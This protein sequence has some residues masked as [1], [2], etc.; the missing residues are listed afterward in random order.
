MSANERLDA[1]AERLGIVDRWH[2]LDGTEQRTG[3]ATKR[4][5]I[6]ALGVDPERTSV[7]DLPPAAGEIIVRAGAPAALPA[8]H[9]VRHWALLDEDGGQIAC[10]GQSLPG[11]AAGLYSLTA[12]TGSGDVERL[13]IAAPERPPTVREAGGKARLWGWTTALYGLRSARNMGLGDYEDLAGCSE[14]LAALGGDFVGINPVHVLGYGPSAPVSPY[15][16]SHRAALNPWHLAIDRLPEFEH[17]APAQ[18]WLSENAGELDRVRG[19][20]T[21][22]YASALA[23]LEPAL[24]ALYTCFRQRGERV[25]AFD[26]WRSAEAGDTLRLYALYEALAEVHGADW[27]TWP[28]GLQA[29]DSPETAREAPRLAERVMF[30]LW[31]QWLAD[32]QLADA[33]ARAKGAGMALGLYLDLAVG[34]RPDGAEVW[35]NRDAFARGA[36]LGAP[37]DAFSPGGQNWAL[38]PLS[39]LGL[40]RQRFA[41]F[42]AMLRATMRHAGLVRIDHAFG[43]MRAFWMPQNGVPGSYIRYPFESLLAIVAIEAQRH[44]C[45]VVGEDL[46]VTPDGFRERLAGAGLYGCDLV[47]FERGWDGSFHQ[48]QTYREAAIASFGTH[49]TPTI[50]GWLR[51]R[52]ID[53]RL[54]IGGAGD[55]AELRADRGR[56]REGLEWA[57][58]QT[59]ALAEGEGSDDTVADAVHHA[60][61]EGS[62]TLTAVQLDDAL[63]EIEQANLPGT[64]DEHPNWRRRVAVP[65]EDLV[66]NPKLVRV[67]AMMNTGRERCSPT[68]ED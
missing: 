40:R 45:I 24:D 32:G 34:S 13:V 8:I 66:S 38:A 46:G 36:T 57:L 1:L 56:S 22:D 30:H 6:A 68:S 20:K 43:L 63:G 12:E 42:I 50:R 28:S 55:E 61:A 11:L 59:G 15:S 58:R 9:D 47:Q 64:V 53:W 3:E 41:P 25:A 29:T 33:Q 18:R 54:S 51:G 62:S 4:E 35:A 19:A 37:P 48:P 21:V 65:V 31:L 44:G 60:L 52:D 10:D 2:S 17:C 27:S 39:P 7:D 5:L 14:A 16:P 49:D 26:A 67:A 23:L